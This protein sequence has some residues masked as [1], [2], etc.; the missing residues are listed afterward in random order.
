VD[1]HDAGI[2]FGCDYCREDQNSFYGHV[3]QIGSDER[4]RMLLLRCPRCGALYEN[5][6]RGPDL[7]RRL[8]EAEAERLFPSFGTL[9][10]E[11][12]RGL[13]APVRTGPAAPFASQV[14]EE[15][16]KR[17][18]DARVQVSWGTMRSE[19]SQIYSAR[20]EH[21]SKHSVDVRG[22]DSFLATLQREPS[23]TPV[24]FVL[25]HTDTHNL[26]TITNPK[27]SRLFGWAAVPLE[28]D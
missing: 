3:T 26:V 25:I 7:T 12:L 11:N 18:V 21:L 1:V 16:D 4:R 2:D 20:R 24:G 15:L 13:L 9:G 23:D 10:A 27:L 17:A 22:L 5:S 6:A 28:W 19:L 8:T 14:L